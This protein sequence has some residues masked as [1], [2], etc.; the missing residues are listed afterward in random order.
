MT[1]L[2]KR[3]HILEEEANHDALTG[4]PNRRV[5][6]D[7]LSQAVMRSNR[8]GKLLAVC[9]LDLDGFKQINDSL[10][11]DAGDDVLRLISG[12][13]SKALRGEDT[14][15]RLGGDEFVLLLGNLDNDVYAEQLLNRLLQDIAQPILLHGVPT[16]VT[17]SI[18]VALYPRTQGTS[19]QLLKHADEAMLA[20]K[21][22]GKSRYHFVPITDIY[23]T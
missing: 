2:V 19:E 13:M 5:L 11:H 23:V 21:R 1:Q 9:Y 7:R 4:L 14:V 15:V 12:R 8:S 20:A 17:V 3:Q 16:G 18:G 22:A 6:Y 10:G